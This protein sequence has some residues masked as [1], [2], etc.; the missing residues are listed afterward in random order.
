MRDNPFASSEQ[1]PNDDF[2]VV[3]PA[4]A[5][6][7]AGRW[8]RLGGAC[9]DWIV[10]VLLWTPVD[11]ALTGAWWWQSFAEGWNETGEPTGNDGGPVAI[12]TEEFAPFWSLAYGDVGTEILAMVLSLGIFLIAQGYLLATRGQT[13]GKLLLGMRIVGSDGQIRPFAATFGLRYGVMSLL[14]WLPGLGALIGLADSVQIFFN[15]HRRCLHDYLAGTWVVRTAVTPPLG[16][17]GADVAP[18]PTLR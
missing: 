2:V 10:Q 13:I 5:R 17:E 4:N 6:H 16:G 8:R 11:Y 18:L 14:C 15:R 3:T 1:P 9:L 7:L 12:E